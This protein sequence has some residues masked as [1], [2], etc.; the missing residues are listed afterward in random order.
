V[1][2]LDE[3]LAV[4]GYQRP[5]W[6]THAACRGMGPD[7]WFPEKGEATRAQLAICATCPVIDPCREYGIE[8]R[9]GIW[10]GTTGNDRRR[11][12]ARR[13]KDTAA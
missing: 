10:G 12:R 2:N 4:L 9:A 5:H 13:A 8:E 6:H 3:L 11:I 1:T 7:R